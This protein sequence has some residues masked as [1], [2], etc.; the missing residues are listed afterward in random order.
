MS[1]SNIINFN[2]KC[3]DKMVFTTSEGQTCEKERQYKNNY[4]KRCK[5]AVAINIMPD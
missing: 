3:V 4:I 1:F 5:L 2:I